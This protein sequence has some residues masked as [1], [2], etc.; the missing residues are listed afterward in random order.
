VRGVVLQAPGDVR[1]EDVDEPKILKPRHAVI[2]L[3]ATC[4]R[5]SDLGRRSRIIA[6]SR[7][8]PRQR[9]TREFGAPDPV[10]ERGD[11]G[12]AR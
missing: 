7:H 4:I 11:E 12:V 6:M 8:E 5:G 10:E 9:L 1:V 3:S 2:R